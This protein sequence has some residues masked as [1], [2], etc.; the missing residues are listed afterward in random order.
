MSTWIKVDKDGRNYNVVPNATPP[1]RWW[2]PTS[3]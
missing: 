1:L 2:N 3:L